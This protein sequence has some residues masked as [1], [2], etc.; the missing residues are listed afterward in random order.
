MKTVLFFILLALHV[1]ANDM[2]SLLY[3]G[4]CI[5][6]HKDTKATSAP[7]ML[8]IQTRYKSAFAKK[9]DFI[10][11]MAKWVE[12]PSKD[13]S[14]MSDAVKKYGLMPHL[15]FDEQTL[16]DISTHIY[17]TDF[18]KSGGRYWSN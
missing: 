9:E 2:N 16:I 10:S 14:L 6:C 13:G 15:S 17:E 5:T 4:N 7:S 3:N 18:S 8:E 1:E 12:N 11:Y